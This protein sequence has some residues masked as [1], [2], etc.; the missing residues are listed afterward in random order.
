MNEKQSPPERTNPACL[1]CQVTSAT[2]PLIA[3]QFRGQNLWICPQHMP[4]LIHEPSQLV[5]RIEGA[6]NWKP[7]DHHD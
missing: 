4:V 6:E 2:V 3:L 7:S 1:V 5:G